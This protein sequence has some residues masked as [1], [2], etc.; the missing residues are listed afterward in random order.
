MIFDGFTNFTLWV[1][2]GI[3]LSPIH[4][5]ANT[6]DNDCSVPNP[7]VVCISNKGLHQA[8]RIFDH[9][10]DGVLI[11]WDDITIIGGGRSDRT[12]FQIESSDTVLL[13]RTSESILRTVF[14]LDYLG[15]R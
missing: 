3:D 5:K 15:R 12:I 7:I 1:G 6:D 4:L 10:I 9:F 11:L 13:H 2:S 14:F 8:T